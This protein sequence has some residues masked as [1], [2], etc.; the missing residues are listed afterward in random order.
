MRDRRFPGKVCTSTLLQI[1]ILNIILRDP[2]D[3]AMLD[4]AIAECQDKKQADRLR[5]VRY[6]LDG[7]ETQEIVEMLGRSRS[8][9]QDWCYAYRDG[10]LKAIKIKIK[11][12][13]GR[14]PKLKPE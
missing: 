10:G 12:Q 4:L 5:A 6:A 9:V 8:F 14:P 7:C 3:D 1:R 13:T 2:A 11:K